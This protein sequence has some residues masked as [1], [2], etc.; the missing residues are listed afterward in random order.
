MHIFLFL[1]LTLYLPVLVVQVVGLTSVLAQV[2][3]NCAYWCMCVFDCRLHRAVQVNK[4]EKFSALCVCLVMKWTRLF[5]SVSVTAKSRSCVSCGRGA[6]N[7]IP[8]PPPPTPCTWTTFSHTSNQLIKT[9]AEVVFALIR[10]C[11]HCDPYHPHQY[12]HQHRHHDLP[13]SPAA[14]RLP[15][16]SHNVPE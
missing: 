8:A 7:I 5:I 10:F 2:P 12:H 11:S 14:P 13:F 9:S 4:T 6:Y 1:H 15:S 3:Y 16:V